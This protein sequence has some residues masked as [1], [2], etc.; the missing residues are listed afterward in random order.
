MTE[1]EHHNAKAAEL[2]R[3][4]AWELVSGDAQVFISVGLSRKFDLWL[5]ED[6]TLATAV[7][8]LGIGGGK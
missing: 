1:P 3:D 8:K 7:R 6:R 5:S 4:I 2:L